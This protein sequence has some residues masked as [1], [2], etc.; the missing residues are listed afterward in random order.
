MT[1][2]DGIGMSYIFLRR[3]F[4]AK[5]MAV[6]VAGL[7]LIGALLPGLVAPAEAFTSWT[8]PADISSGTNNVFPR[9][10]MSED[11]TRAVAIWVVDTSSDDILYAASARISGTSVTW[12]TPTALS[13]AGFKAQE[14]Q[15]QVSDDGTTAV[16]IWYSDGSSDSIQSSVGTLSGATDVWKPATVEAV[17]TSS[18]PQVDISANGSIAVATWD[19]KDG[20]AKVIRSSF[21]TISAGAATW[22]ASTV[23]SDPIKTATTSHV[24]MSD[25]GT[26][27]VAVWRRGNGPPLIPEARVATF[28]GTTAS[29]GTVDVLSPG[30]DVSTQAVSISAD[31]STVATVWSLPND[32]TPA[33]QSVTGSV[34]AN[35]AAWGTPATLN[36]PSER[37]NS[38]TIALSADGKTA[39]AAWA[40]DINGAGQ[41]AYIRSRVAAVT[42]SSATWGTSIDTVGSDPGQCSYPRVALTADGTQASA[43]WKCGVLQTG[44]ATIAATT[45]PSATWAA[46]TDLTASGLNPGDLN[47]AMASNGSN[48]IAVW[49]LNKAI[50]FSSAGTA[51]TPAPPTPAPPAPPGPAPAPAPEPDSTPTA[52]PTPTPTASASSAPMADPLDPI[53]TTRNPNIPV[54][55]VPAGGSVFLVN[56]QPAPVT[57]KPNATANPTSL[58]VDAPGLTMRLQG[59]NDVNDPLGLTSS[60]ALILQSEPTL[61][62]RS[63]DMARKAKVQPAAVSSGTGF[64]PNSVV[65]F[66]VLPGTYLGELPTD[67]VGKYEG[68]VPVTAGLPVGVHTLQANGYAPDGSVRSLSLGVLVKASDASVRTMRAASTVRFAENSSSLSAE[69]KAVLRALVKKTGKTPITVASLGYVQKSGSSAND[70]ALSTARARA[71]GAYLRSLGVTGRYSVRGDGVGGPGAANRKVV[72]TITYRK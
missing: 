52:T 4:P 50:Q 69:G 67:S 70:Q 66:Y 56:G 18:V 46:A 16:A 65:K 48:A 51:P 41:T 63:L 68:R 3:T 14:P 11:G 64:K 43:I 21:A 15:V 29:W 32:A 40:R 71:V 49:E 7:G 35:E 31:G 19:G 57:V 58:L 37:A 30:A 38:T 72:V 39:L 5:R 45:P 42:G 61:R 2:P 54:G 6:T 25:S 53:G 27:A 17:T 22:G 24:A 26:T 20:S 47:I 23:L 8:P 59:R 34:S 36:D 28:D 12:G 33:A 1:S 13:G 9:L 44:S 55:G 10:A 62:S 60:Q